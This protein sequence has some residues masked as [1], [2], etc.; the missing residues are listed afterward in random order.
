MYIIF[1]VIVVL[2]TALGS[3]FYIF[4][5]SKNIEESKETEIIESEEVAIVSK[6]R[7]GTYSSTES[8][9]TPKRIKHDI[10]VTLDIENNVIT[11]VDVKY[12]GNP[13]KSPSHRKFDSAYKQITTGVRIDELE[14][15]RIGGSTLTTYAFVDAI[16]NIREEA[17]RDD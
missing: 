17:A 3:A 5:T 1:I 14:A 10:E 11:G 7:D 12:D 6:Y 13:A 4:E 8:Y 2:I 15:S 9:Y 16:D